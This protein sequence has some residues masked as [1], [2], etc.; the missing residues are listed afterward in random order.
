MPIAGGNLMLSNSQGAEQM[1]TVQDATAQKNAHGV[2]IEETKLDGIRVTRNNA[3]L[4][5]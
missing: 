5:L 4:L 3:D 1:F 2:I